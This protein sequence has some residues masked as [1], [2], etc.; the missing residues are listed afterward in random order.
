[1]YRK[2]ECTQNIAVFFLQVG[3][4]FIHMPVFI[5]LLQPFMEEIEA[6]CILMFLSSFQ[7]TS[8]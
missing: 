4:H 5:D 2:N 1:M 7:N 8:D 6:E 3:A